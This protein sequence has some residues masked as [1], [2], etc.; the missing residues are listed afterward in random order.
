MIRSYWHYLQINR[1]RKGDIQYLRVFY[2]K[3]DDFLVSRKDFDSLV[4]FAFKWLFER[5]VEL[6][7]NSK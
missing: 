6:V 1:W 7:E 4:T 5:E 2:S 3:Q